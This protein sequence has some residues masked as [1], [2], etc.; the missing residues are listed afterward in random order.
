LE[1]GKPVARGRREMV[2]PDRKKE[3]KERA[4]RKGGR[5]SP[6]GQAHEALSQ[7]DRKGE[8]KGKRKSKKGRK[9][10]LPSDRAFQETRMP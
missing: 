1:K 2:P 6:D 8:R 4:A 9:R 3:K 10:D 5:I 7:C